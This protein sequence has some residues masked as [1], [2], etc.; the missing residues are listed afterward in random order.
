MT[1]L[2]PEAT[3]ALITAR[4]YMECKN[5]GR[6]RVHYDMVLTDYPESWEAFFYYTYCD[7]MESEASLGAELIVNC[8]NLVLEDIKRLEDTNEQ[9]KAIKQI[10]SDLNNYLLL[11]LNNYE[12][13]QKSST[14]NLGVLDGAKILINLENIYVNDIANLAIMLKH[15][16]DNLVSVIGENELTKSIRIQ[17]YEDIFKV[18]PDTFHDEL[19]EVNPSSPVLIKY[20]S[21]SFWKK[22]DSFDKGMYGCITIFVAF[23]VITLIIESF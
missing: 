6:A 1:Q 13:S 4:R 17:C 12:I 21:R 16:G 11:T 14:R 2:S 5:Y 20:D 8:I 19:K 15:F 9:N 18:L 3:N 22:L 7:A 10:H 23:V